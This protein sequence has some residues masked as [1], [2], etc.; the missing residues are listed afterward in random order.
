MTTTLMLLPGLM[1]DEA[2]WVPQVAAL[3]P[4]VRCIVPAWGLLDSLTEMARK[5]LDGAPQ[6]RFS[7]AGHSMG[8]RV[9]MEVQRLAPDRVERLALLDTGYKPLA[10]GEAG[11]RER[12]LRFGLLEIARAQGMRAMAEQWAG[13]MVH[14][15]RLGTPL[16]EEVLAMISRSSPA[17]FAAQI[18]ALLNRPD[19]GAHL[20][21]IR[22]PTLVLCGREDSWSPVAQHEA[23][24]AATPGASLVIVEHCGHMCTMEQPGEVNQALAAWLA[25]PT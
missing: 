1:C 8:G 22:C 11:E 14:P 20:G 23:I 21:A 25:T 3:S 5:V 7:V 13:G 19:A 6:G 24:H 10:D 9:A 17:Q 12:A 18:N 15:D 16:F 2:V 4:G